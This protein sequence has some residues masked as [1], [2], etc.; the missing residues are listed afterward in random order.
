MASEIKMLRQQQEAF[1]KERASYKERNTHLKEDLNKLKANNQRLQ[2]KICTEHKKCKEMADAKVQLE[3]N[4]EIDLELLY[5]LGCNLNHPRASSP[6]LSFVRDRCSSAS[7][8]YTSD[9]EGHLC[10]ASP[11]RS[12]ASSRGSD[13][14]G[15]K[16]SGTN[17]RKKVMG[18]TPSPPILKDPKWKKDFSTTALIN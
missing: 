5:N 16:F 14:S 4:R 11:G 13:R 9:D 8:C 12:R 3:A 10:S 6:I 18:R 17:T 1:D 2:Q 7:S 15:P